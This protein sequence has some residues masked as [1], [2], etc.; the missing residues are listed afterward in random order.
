MKLSPRNASF[1]LTK[2]P[3]LAISLQMA[4]SN[5]MKPKL[6]LLKKCKHRMG[7][8]LCV[9]FSEKTAPLRE[10]LRND[11]HWRWGPAQQQAFHT[12]KADISQ[13]PVLRYFDPSKP[14][15][16]SVDASKSGL[17]AACLQVGFPGAYASRAQT[18]VETQYAQIEKI[19]LSATFACRK[20]HDF[21]YGQQGTIETNRSNHS[22][23][24]QTPS[25]DPSSSSAYAFA[26]SEV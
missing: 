21:I 17:G 24:K 15:T 25:I 19:L 3:M 16:L 7:Q 20:F 6:Q 14:V 23:R 2:C 10:L 26:A 13:P 5:P 11:A 9:D 12:L 1:A 18:K 22:N 8:R 4:V